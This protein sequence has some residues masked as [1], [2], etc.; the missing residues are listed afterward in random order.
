[1][2]KK[3]FSYDKYGVSIGRWYRSSLRGKFEGIGRRLGL[4]KAGA[5]EPPPA[6][7]GEDGEPNVLESLDYGLYVLATCLH[8]V[9]PLAVPATVYF[10]TDTPYTSFREKWPRQL[11]ASAKIEMIPGTHLTCI[12]HYPQVLADKLGETFKQLHETN[13]RSA[14][15]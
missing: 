11:F 13:P 1:L 7:P 4:T 6:E 3:I 10:P 14:D 12:S 8:H 15:G 5:D 2:R 9:E